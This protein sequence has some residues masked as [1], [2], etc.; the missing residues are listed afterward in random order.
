MDFI[1]SN[2]PFK[3]DF[4]EWR[5]DVE[6]LPNS[7]ERFFA[8]V[9]TIP[10]KDKDKMAIY[11]LFIQHILYSLNDTG[12]AA[13]VVP[14]GFISSQSWIEK[15][16]RERI[17]DK[18]WL[19]WVVSMPSNI[20]ATTGTNVS[21]IFI[22]KT[23]NKWDEIILIDASKLWETVKEWKNQKTYLRDNEQQQIINTFKNMEVVEDFSVKVT[24]DQIKEKNYSRSA[25]QYFEIKIEHTDI[26]AEEFE[27]RMNNYKQN[28]KGYFEEWKRLEDDIFNQL[29]GLKYE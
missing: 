1:V 3:L 6:Q 29:S 9:P 10:N 2:P 24:N 8:W 23:R 7:Q 12:K 11:L 25:W 22:D 15:R 26:T 27:N 18:N 5:D 20:F 21:V 17:V 16:I 14:T 28:L 19:K 13:I 4:S